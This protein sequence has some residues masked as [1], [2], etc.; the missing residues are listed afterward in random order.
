MK[1]ILLV[2]T[3]VSVFTGLFALPN[4]QQTHYRWR[5]DD[6]NEASATWKAAEDT[7]ITVNAGDYSNIRLRL[8]IQ[9]VIT[10]EPSA[11]QFSPG[12]ISYNNEK[13]PLFGDGYTQITTDSSTN[14][15][16]LVSSTWFEDGEPA[17]SDLLYNDQYAHTSDPGNMYDTSSSFV[18]NDLFISRD[19]EYEFCIAPTVNAI[20]GTTYY[21]KIDG[22]VLGHFNSEPEVVN[23]SYATIEISAGA[24]GSLWISE[25]CDNKTGSDVG[26]GFLEL[27]NDTGSAVSLDGFSLQQGTQGESGFV[28]GAYSYS[29]P[30]GYSIPD[31]GY[32]VIGNGADLATFNTA[33]S[34]ALT[35]AEYDSGHGNLDFT[36]GHAYAIDDGSKALLDETP[37]VAGGDRVNQESGQSWPIS[38]PEA[39]TPGELGADG[40]L[41]VVLSAFTAIQTLTDFAQI[42]WTTQ[43]ESD[44]SGY[45]I[46][47]NTIDQNETAVK[48]N[49]VL[50]Q[51]TNTTDEQNYSYL[52][53]TVEVTEYY[54]WLES[55]ELAGNTELFGPISINIEYQPDNPTPPTTVVTG[56]HQNYP[57]PFN[58]QT[59]I[60]FALGQPGKA[61]LVIY[62]V[63][64]QKV[65]TLFNDHANANEYIT[66]NWDGT[67]SSGNKVSSGVY[68][69]KLRTDNKEYMKKMILMK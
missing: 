17:T 18:S 47:R 48:I 6:G 67:D 38:A 2:F 10:E 63:K 64:G 57:N 15:F 68:M 23:D 13:N 3:L 12:Y 8:S 49:P 21:M 45:N 24:E 69:Y 1:K 46:Y 29:I 25:V 65:V 58:P 11:G 19:C 20:P 41:P 43:S 33:W 27:W 51:G 60:Q 30:A 62:N 34:L 5:N 56:L 4:F 40:P 9:N 35:A 61:Q 55:V 22:T 32:F 31:G 37:E 14:A 50:I 36:N 28:P 44:I 59:K 39:G 42:N 52:D 7:P 66:V 26:T 54:Y 53:E 16:V